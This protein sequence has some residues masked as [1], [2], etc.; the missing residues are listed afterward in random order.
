MLSVLLSRLRSVV[1]VRAI[2][3]W[4]LDRDPKSVGSALAARGGCVVTAT[5]IPT[6]VVEDVEL[7]SRPGVLTTLVDPMDCDH[8]WEPHLWETGRAYCARCG[9]HARWV[10]DPRS[11]EERS[12]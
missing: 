10:N 6:M 12:S 5:L 8:F 4:P 7:R 3:G 1:A 11:A 9:S 2:V